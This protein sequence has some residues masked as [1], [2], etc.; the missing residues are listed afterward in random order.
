MSDPVPT[1]T[2][3][4]PA[5]ETDWKAEARKW[6]ERSKENKASVD[7]L[8]RERD[9]ALAKAVALE[10]SNAE[11]LEKVNLFE[12]EKAHAELVAKVAESVGVDPKA[13]RGSTEDELTE[14]ANYLKELLGSQS[15]APVIPSQGKTPEQ[16]K[17]DPFREFTRNL[18]ESAKHD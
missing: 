9:D 1:P 14:H 3:A 13:L 12:S 16:V 18:F 15:S 5:Q 4:P 11:L 2:P 17:E 8:T 7:A 6:E 10:S